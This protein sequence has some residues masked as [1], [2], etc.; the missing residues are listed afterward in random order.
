M[1]VPCAGSASAVVGAGRGPQ[2][3]QLRSWLAVGNRPCGSLLLTMLV[4]LSGCSVGV[5]L[6]VISFAVG[7]ETAQMVTI[8]LGLVLAIVA[9]FMQRSRARNMC[10]TTCT[11][12]QPAVEYLHWHGSSHSFNIL[13]RNYAALFMLANT[14]KLVNVTEDGRQLM[15]WAITQADATAVRDEDDDEIRITVSASTPSTRVP[16]PSAEASDHDRLVRCLSKL[17]SL[18]GSASRRAAVE[19]AMKTITSE[20]IRKRLLLEASRIEV[21]AVL[22]KV[23]SLKTKSAKKRTL[24]AAIEEIKATRYPTSCKRSRSRCLKRRFAT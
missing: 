3:D 9:I 16:R 1:C 8:L 11:A 21:S 4:E 17:E 10:S 7:N 6:I 20:E 12:P 24:L 14:K 5:V 18:K 2:F 23:D 15:Q 19:A 22:D 13:S